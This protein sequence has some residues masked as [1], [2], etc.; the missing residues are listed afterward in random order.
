MPWEK[1]TKLVKEDTVWF[2]GIYFGL[3]FISSLISFVAPPPFPLQPPIPVGPPYHP[4]KRSITSAF[5]IISSSLAAFVAGCAVFSKRSA[6]VR[7]HRQ[8][9]DKL[10]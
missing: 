4:L 8:Q 2:H 7:T 6:L 9:T 10:A 1:G 5:A 3:I